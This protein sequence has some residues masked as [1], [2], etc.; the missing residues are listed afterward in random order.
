MSRPRFHADAHAR[1]L[2]VRDPMD[3]LFSHHLAVLLR[4]CYTENTTQPE[5]VRLR[6]GPMLHSQNIAR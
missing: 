5:C 3:R 6:R 4:T 2:Q 1:P